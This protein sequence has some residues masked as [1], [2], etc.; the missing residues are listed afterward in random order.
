[1]R[2]EHLRQWKSNRPWV[3]HD[4]YRLM[5]KEDV[6]ILAYEA[7]KS[8][9]GN[10]TPGTDEE[11]LAGFSLEA[12]EEIIQEM[13]TEQFRLKPVRTTFIPKATGKMRKL[14][15]PCVRE[16]V[17]QEVM[18]RILE[19]I[20]DSPHG[21]YFQETRHGF[22]PNRSGQT[23]LREVRGKW[24]ARNWLIE[25]D[26]RAGFD[27]LDLHVVVT[28]LHKKIHDQRFLNLI[29]KLLK[30]GYM[31]LHGIKRESLIGSPREVASA[32]S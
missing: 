2:L 11:T 3:N 30:A 7:I 24:T 8:K 5:Y 9:P 17:V 6:Y 16:K 12:I 32:P 21:P 20:Y 26:I 31:D 18:P 22:R 25:G 29:W 10:M 4:V 15:I 1:M 23:A 13:R 27:E 14:G 28:L 19:A